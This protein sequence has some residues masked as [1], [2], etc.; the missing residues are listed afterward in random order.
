M[1]ICILSDRRSDRKKY[2]KAFTALLWNDIIGD[3]LYESVSDGTRTDDGTALIRKRNA[4]AAAYTDYG[5]RSGDHR[6]SDVF[7]TEK[8]YPT[9]AGLRKDIEKAVYF[10]PNSR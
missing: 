2:N 1:R 4:L 5:S 9:E 8:Q 10:F 7:D 6:D 3:I